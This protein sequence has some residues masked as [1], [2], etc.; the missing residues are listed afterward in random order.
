ML[1]DILSTLEEIVSVDKDVF[2]RILHPFT[3][4]KKK[5]KAKMI[6]RAYPRFL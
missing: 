5:K 2:S 3:K 4:Q 6:A 1:N